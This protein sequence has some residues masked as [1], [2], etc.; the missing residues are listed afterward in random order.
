[1]LGVMQGICR[2]AGEERRGEERRECSER[3]QEQRK[4]LNRAIFLGGNLLQF[5]P[6][7]TSRYLLLLR[8]S[9]RWMDGN[10]TLS[11]HFLREAILSQ[12]DGAERTDGLASFL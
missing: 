3:K 12:L 10:G 2:C 4:E 7:T 9:E 8:A 11:P 1:M 5:V 6:P